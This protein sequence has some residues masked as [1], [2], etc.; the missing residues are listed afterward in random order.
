MVLP[1]REAGLFFS[2]MML[3]LIGHLL[4]EQ[5][6]FLSLSLHL[7][8][9]LSIVSSLSG[10]IQVF[11]TSLV[12]AECKLQL[13][14]QDARLAYERKV[15]HSFIVER[16]P[17]LFRHIRDLSGSGKL[18]PIMYY[19]SSS[20]DNARDKMQLFNQFFHS[21]FKHPNLLDPM[22]P[23][24]DLPEPYLCLIDFNIHGTF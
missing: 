4:R 24:S 18:P 3:T 15:L 22:S 21:V 7:W 19:M 17:T 12:C 2:Q 5:S 13:N 16:D 8:F 20:A 14:I 11:G 10:S 1:W 23:S 6:S 9:I